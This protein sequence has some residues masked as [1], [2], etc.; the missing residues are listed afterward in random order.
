MSGPYI[1]PFG[2]VISSSL[3]MGD[4]PDVTPEL[5]ENFRLE[6]GQIEQI[7]AIDDPE[8]SIPGIPARYT[9]CDVLITRQTGATELLPRCRIL[10]PAFGGGINNFLEV[11]PTNPG[12]QA[13]NGAIP[14]DLKP[15]H[16]VL[17][18]F[19]SGRKDAGVIL[20]ALPHANRTAIAR[21]PTKDKG[22]YLEGEVQG[23]GF[24]IDNNGAL[25]LVF[26]GPRKDDGTLIDT[27]IGPTTVQI[28]KQG[29]LTIQTN[30]QQT[31]L[32]DRVGTTI[33]I[34]NGPTYVN[35]DQGANKIQVVAKTVEVGTNTLQP[36][37]VGDDWKSL[38]EDLITEITQIIVP[39]GV[40]PSGTPVN[41]PK[42]QAIKNRLKECLSRNHK[43]EK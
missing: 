3:V 20:G 16:W 11:L 33:K 7:Y 4:A 8:N 36:Q 31:V 35:M 23:F 12:P 40:G 9:V 14:K 27:T 34:T 25:S 10:Q 39:T 38:M 28:D 5:R 21:R 37:L 41:T 18:G 26:N 30:Q 42:F 32:I 24:S 2:D 19:V 13:K 29:S 17:V 6:T 15:G 22:T 43:V 1:S